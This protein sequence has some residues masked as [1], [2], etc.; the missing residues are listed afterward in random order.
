VEA[1]VA[2]EPGDGVDGELTTFPRA[3]GTLQVAYDGAP[4][5]YFANDTTPGD[6]NGQGL[7][8]NWFVAEP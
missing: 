4:L 6:T 1:D 5:Y 2:F 8:D 3:D 7:G